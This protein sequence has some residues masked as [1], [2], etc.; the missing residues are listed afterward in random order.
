MSTVF[1]VV[2]MRRRKLKQLIQQQDDTDTQTDRQTDRHT[3][4]ERGS[5]E[6]RSISLLCVSIIVVATSASNNTCPS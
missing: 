3:H 1:T 4:R 5:R 6:W 2:M